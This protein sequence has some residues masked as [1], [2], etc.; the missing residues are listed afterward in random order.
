MEAQTPPL[1]ESSL[2]AKVRV[3]CILASLRASPFNL[4]RLSINLRFGLSDPRLEIRDS[5]LEMRGEVS[6]TETKNL[7]PFRFSPLQFS[8][9]RHLTT[10]RYNLA[11]GFFCYLDLRG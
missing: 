4:N 1:R 3:G 8:P 9:E 2:K 5:S 11:V 6:P 7:S 10:F